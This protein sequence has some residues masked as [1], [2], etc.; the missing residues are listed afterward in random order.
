MFFL[1]RSQD[2][3]R[4]ALFS[5]V[6]YWTSSPL[7]F[8][9]WRGRR[10]KHFAPARVLGCCS[11]GCLCSLRCKSRE[12]ASSCLL[13]VCVCVFSGCGYHQGFPLSLFSF[14]FSTVVPG[15]E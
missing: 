12:R 8:I 10:R 1:A 2:G 15:I 4:V 14:F 6:S 7:F 9:T 11:F 3:P 5:L 13:C